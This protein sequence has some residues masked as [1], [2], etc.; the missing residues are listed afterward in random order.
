[1]PE[2]IGNVCSNMQFGSLVKFGYLLNYRRAT[3]N[4]LNKCMKWDYKTTKKQNKTKGK[5]FTGKEPEINSRIPPRKNF[6]GQFIASS[7]QSQPVL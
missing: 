3:K 6:Q 5:L 1:M 2:Y 4:R 7:V